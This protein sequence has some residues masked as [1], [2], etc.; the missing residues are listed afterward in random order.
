MAR[1]GQFW[2]RWG[3]T[4]ASAAMLISLGCQTEQPIVARTPPPNDPTVLPANEVVTVRGLVAAPAGLAS[5]DHI[6]ATQDSG[7]FYKIL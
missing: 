5:G 3:M 6:V 4:T 2:A 1:T 7:G